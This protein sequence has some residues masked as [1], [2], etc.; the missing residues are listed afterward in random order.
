MPR[1]ITQTLPIFLTLTLLAGSAA[2]QIAPSAVDS[3][4]APRLGPGTITRYRTGAVITA[5]N[6]AV[7]NIKAMVAAPLECPEQT[8]QT[9]EEDVSPTVTGFDYRLLPGDGARQMLIFIP[10]L[11]SG[12][13]ARAVITYEVVT[14]TILPPEDPSLLIEP[15][16]R[17]REAKQY[18]GPSPFIDVG[19]R[20]IKKAVAEAL[21][22]L[23]ETESDESPDEAD[24]PT[25]AKE[26]VDAEDDA[27]P[28]NEGGA[29]KTPATTVAAAETPSS[30]ESAAAP[31]AT[32]ESP[33]AEQAVA[34]AEPTA[35][36]RVEALYDYAID[37][38]E[39]EEGVDKSSVQV[40]QDG[41]GDCQAIGALFVAMCRTAKIPA[42]LV[43]VHEHQYAEFYLTDA[44][45]NG[46]WF[47]VETAGTPAFGEMRIARVILQK[48]DNFRVPER[49]G[50][51]LRYASDYLT[52][53]PTPGGGKPGV[54]YIRGMQ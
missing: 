8:V 20:K 52:G 48:G 15:N 24:E 19:H 4:A 3:P 53:L 51:R 5:K 31:D 14:H 34:T 36:Q 1:I 28:A 26:S 18:L 49:R 35:W 2:A 12:A 47:P 41:V 21:A 6:G 30:E 7:R 27:T 37:H 25:D 39:Y 38:V 10:N 33:S 44:Q 29:A 46:Y 23:E 43:W 16:R 17:D 11:P 32:D 9:V 45:G 40:L 22:A 42:R 54:K 50:E 13:E